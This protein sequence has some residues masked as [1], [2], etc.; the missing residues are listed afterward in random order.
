MK[1][2]WLPKALV[3]ILLL[4]APGCV[5]AVIG[6]AALGGYAISPDTVEGLT[7]R[8][9][10]AVWDAVVEVLSIMGRVT[11]Q[12]EQKGMVVAQVSGAKVTVTIY[13][14]SQKTVKLRVKARKSFLPKIA[15]AQDVFAKIMNYLNE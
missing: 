7:A 15:I 8:D 12:Y 11:E 4:T 1:N 13:T 14:M 9:E 3:L 10:D 5:A 2:F 6:T